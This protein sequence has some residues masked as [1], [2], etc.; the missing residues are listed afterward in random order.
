MKKL[1]LI[2]SVFA[3]SLPL[4]FTTGCASNLYP[5]GP[6][7]AGGIVTHV[8]SPAQHLAVALDK[9]AK[10][11]KKGS[12]N[13]T[14]ILGMFAFGDSGVHTA[15]QKAGISRVH[16]VDHTVNMFLGGWLFATDTTIVYG[17]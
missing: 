2:V 6:S 17:E 4:M 13:T 14:A 9:D 10:P 15:M 5:G 3:V 12:G 8:T 16:H 7:V 1:A 11:T